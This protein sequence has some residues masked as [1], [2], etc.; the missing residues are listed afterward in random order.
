MDRY[1]NSKMMFT[2][3]KENIFYRV[4]SSVTRKMTSIYLAISAYFTRLR[5]K[6]IVCSASTRTYSDIMSFPRMALIKFWLLS[7]RTF[8][9]AKIFTPSKIFFFTFITIAY[10]FYIFAI[11][12]SLISSNN[13]SVSRHRSTIACPQ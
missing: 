12:I 3:K 10:V 13:K 6:N 9:T 4:I 1:I 5:Y 7:F 8:N 11:L 2:A